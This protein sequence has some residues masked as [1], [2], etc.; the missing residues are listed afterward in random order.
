LDELI[1]MLTFTSPNSNKNS[2]SQPAVFRSSQV[3]APATLK[4]DNF[5][6]AGA[7]SNKN[8]FVNKVV[9]SLPGI[10]SI[11]GIQSNNIHTFSN[12]SWDMEDTNTNKVR[13]GNQ[14]TTSNKS[15]TTSSAIVPKVR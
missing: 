5:S 14:F 10:D 8:S 12:D 13:T 2:N 15:S 4:Q 6:S 3:N 9:K 11:N 1:D 7:L